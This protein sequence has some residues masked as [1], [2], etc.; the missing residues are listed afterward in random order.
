MDRP[1]TEQLNIR[2]MSVKDVPQVFDIERESFNDSSWTIDAF[3]HEIEQNEFATYFVIEYDDKIIGYLGLW[4]VI[5]QA[6][7]TTVAI[8][9]QFRGFGLGQ[10]LLEYVKN[11]ASHTC[12]VMSLE[13]RIGNEI[14]QHVYKNLGFQYG[15]KRKNYY[16]EGEDAIVMWVNLK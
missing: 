16:G 4:I 12:E 14:A 8:T 6:Q 2:K 7:I 11:Y 13:A 1:T 15:G 5:D 9:H 10:L 3:Y